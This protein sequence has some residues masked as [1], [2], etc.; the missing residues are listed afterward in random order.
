MFW[1]SETLYRSIKLAL[2]AL[3]IHVRRSY[4]QSSLE[5]H[6]KCALDD[7]DIDLVIDV[8][9]NVGQFLRLIRAIGYKGAILSF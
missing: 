4:T 6:L 1:S 9:A 7:F 3:G 2:L 8:G 5:S